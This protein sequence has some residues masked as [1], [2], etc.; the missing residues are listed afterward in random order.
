MKHS[1]ANVIVVALALGGSAAFPSAGS[2]GSA[3]ATDPV[4]T[5]SAASA[6]GSYDPYGDFTNDKTA[7]IEELF[8]P[9]ED[10]DLSTLP[11]ADTYAQE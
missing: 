7:S 6:F 4:Q 1:A 2:A 8:L 10:V 11:L 5:S 9:W 3:P